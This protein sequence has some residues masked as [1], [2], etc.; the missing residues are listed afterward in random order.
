M[1]AAWL[2]LAVLLLVGAPDGLGASALE[3]RFT[4]RTGLDPDLVSVLH[5]AEP[6]QELVLA[7]VYVSERT[8]EAQLSEHVAAILPEYVGKNA[9]VV[10]AYSQYEV[11]WDPGRLSFAQD[12]SVVWA[13][14]DR[15]VPVTEG[16]EA[17]QL[18]P[19]RTVAGVVL[20]GDDID[21]TRTFTISYGD[22]A[23]TEMDVRVELAADE[24]KQPV[25][26]RSSEA[27]PDADE[28]CE[29]C[30][31]LFGCLEDCVDPCDPCSSGP[32]LPLIFL[33]LLGL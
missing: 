7:L 25:A 19:D 11:P 24:E 30:P 28:G 27:E 14:G 15:V 16:F 9:V 6:G 3:D 20:L 13:T 23:Y 32:I 8:L 12:D 18:R 31:P 22:T 17:S 1:R 33:F 4:D 10:S 29:P 26:V 2:A 21:P 5:V